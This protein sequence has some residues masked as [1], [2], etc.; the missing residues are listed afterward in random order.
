MKATVS[1]VL[2]KS[3]T[4]KNGEH[5]LMLRVI[6]DRKPK[7]ISIGLSCKAKDWNF[8]K[9]IPKSKHPQHDLIVEV[10]REKKSEYQKKIFELKLEKK[11]VSTASLIKTVEDEDYSN[12]SLFSFFDEI[13]KR[14]KDSNKIGTAKSYQ[15]TKSS[16]SIFLE[17]RDI[18]FSEIDYRFLVKY[19]AHLRKRNVNSNSI[20]V[21]MRTLRALYNK[22][23]KE[24]VVKKQYY[25]FDEYKISNLKI[26]PNRRAIS[27]EDI[28]SIEKLELEY[29]LKRYRARQYFLFSFYCHGINFIDIAKLK[30]ENIIEDDRLV[31]TRSKTGK[32]FNIEILPPVLEI[33]TYWKSKTFNNREDYI[34]PIL[35][36]DFHKTATQIDNRVRKVIKQVN[37]ELKEIGKA[38][39]IET[40]LTT[41]VAR[42]T[43]A[44]VLKNKGIGTSVIS[45]MMGHDKEETTTSYL[46]SFGNNVID[47]A[48]KKLL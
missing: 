7:Y 6:K 3:K 23:I 24:N 31:Y 29:G 12:T 45:E 8:E 20:A 35:R 9:N 14:L 37:K 26:T 4:L 1:V 32:I 41:Y 47:N 39:S 34:F 15:F 38:A 36:I 13:F 16:L 5:P 44:T 33:L 19:E 10:M 30:W 17:G 46:K 28:K 2:Y 27:H 42:H 25:P 11:E 43:F 40:P 22:A 48:S 21:Y 18:E